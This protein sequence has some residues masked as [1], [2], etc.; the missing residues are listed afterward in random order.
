[1]AIPIHYSRKAL[2]VEF[3]RCLLDDVG[4]K[5]L[6]EI[7]DRNKT[8]EY[9]LCCAS[10]D[11]CDANMTMLRAGVQL[12]YWTEESF[13]CNGNDGVVMSEAWDIAKAHDMP[14]RMW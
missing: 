8:P 6:G 4:E 11:F 5:A 10:H 3:S 1:M 7:R 14:L 12:G 9:K 13:D 2:A